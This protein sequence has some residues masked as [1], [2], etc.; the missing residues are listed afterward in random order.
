MTPK[1]YRFMPSLFYS[2]NTAAIIAPKR[3]YEYETLT[4]AVQDDEGSVHRHL[5]RWFR[6]HAI[7]LLLEVVDRDIMDSVTQQNA[8][9]SRVHIHPIISVICIADK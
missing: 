8:L 5:Q 4:V 2:T 1:F 7:Y 6:V 9:T 3:K